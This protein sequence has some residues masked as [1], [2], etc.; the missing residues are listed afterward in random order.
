MGAGGKEKS[1]FSTHLVNQIS[2][3]KGPDML[4]PVQGKEKENVIFS[5]G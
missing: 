3:G 4:D 5:F 2:W 1:V